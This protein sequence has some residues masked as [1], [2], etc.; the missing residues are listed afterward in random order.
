MEAATKVLEQHSQAMPAELQPWAWKN[1]VQW[2]ALAVVLAELTVRSQDRSSDRAYSVAAQ[3]FRHYARLVADS[4]SGLLWKP[5]ARLMRR[6]QR[7]RQSACLRPTRT[8]LNETATLDINP[9]IMEQPNFVCF[10]DNDMFNVATQGVDTEL[11]GTT[12]MSTEN[13]VEGQYNGT[14]SSIDTPW[15]AWDLFIRDIEYTVP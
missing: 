15:L 14:G 4:E 1:W 6:V 3:S 10:D 5:I 7:M 2:H 8:F 11:L 9:V 13:Y 12:F